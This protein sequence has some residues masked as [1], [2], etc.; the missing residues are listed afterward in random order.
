MELLNFFNT[1]EI[2]RKYIE[3]FHNLLLENNLTYFQCDLIDLLLKNIGDIPP[4][5][6]S[7]I[8]GLYHKHSFPMKVAASAFD[9]NACSL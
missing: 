5:I 7:E 8:Y 6:I 9:C 4:E 1:F 2:Q 3:L